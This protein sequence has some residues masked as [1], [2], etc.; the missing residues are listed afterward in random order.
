[1]IEPVGNARYSPVVQST[2]Y[3]WPL[4]VLIATFILGSKCLL[5]VVCLQVCLL[6]VVAHKS[7]SPVVNID[8]IFWLEDHSPLGKV[9]AHNCFIDCLPWIGK[10]C[11][12]STRGK[13][14]LKSGD[15]H[16]KS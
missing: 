12:Y 9:C 5:V 13:L 6:V 2:D 14:W 10:Y 4:S 16:Y 3:G 11:N 15:S 7:T 1:M 8:T